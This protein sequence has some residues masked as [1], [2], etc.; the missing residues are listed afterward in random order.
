MNKKQ[1]KILPYLSFLKTKGFY[2]AGGTALALRIGHRTSLDFD[3]YTGKDFKPEQIYSQ[4]QE[5]KPREIF[6]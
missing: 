5:E 3:F 1:A 4:F 2:L 6:Y